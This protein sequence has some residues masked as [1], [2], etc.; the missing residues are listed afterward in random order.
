MQ[1]KSCMGI[2]IKDEETKKL[3]TKVCATNIHSLFFAFSIKLPYSS[4][5]SLCK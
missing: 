5:S 3:H 1:L 2:N 4:E